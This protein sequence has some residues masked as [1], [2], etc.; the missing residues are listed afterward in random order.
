MSPDVETSPERATF[1]HVVIISGGQGL[2]VPESVLTSQLEVEVIFEVEEMR[3]V[4]TALVHPNVLS[5][6]VKIT[7]SQQYVSSLND[8]VQLLRIRSSET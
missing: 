3:V 4:K 6:I 8:Q 5:Y 7:K 1:P 2:M